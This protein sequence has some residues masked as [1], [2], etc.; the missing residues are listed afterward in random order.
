MAMVNRI[1]V[2]LLSVGLASLLL[3]TERGSRLL[4]GIAS[5]AARDTCV[6]GIDS[7]VRRSSTYMENGKTFITESCSRTVATWQR[8]GSRLTLRSVQAFEPAPWLPDQINIYASAD[9]LVAYLGKPHKVDRGG[10][11]DMYYYK[12]GSHGLIVIQVPTKTG[13]IGSVSVEFQ[14]AMPNNSFKPT[15]LRGA[16]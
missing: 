8:Q 16:A 14:E 2:I 5:N 6:T 7:D 10:L 4:A 3:Y 13:V 12:V 1:I 15:P 9:N 11:V